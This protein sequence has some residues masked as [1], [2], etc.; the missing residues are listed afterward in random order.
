MT[1][2]E[3]SSGIL[4]ISDCPTLRPCK[5]PVTPC[6]RKHEASSD[7]ENLTSPP[8]KWRH[9]GGA[10]PLTEN[11][12]FFCFA[13]HGANSEDDAQVEPL[14]NIDVEPEQVSNAFQCQWSQDSLWIQ[15]A[16]A[17]LLATDPKA[18]WNPR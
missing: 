5:M 2:L 3:G 7:L 6:K 10:S 9:G 12:V 4:Q 16:R 18:L 14:L 15:K 13:D 11:E 17:T 1:L 8:Q